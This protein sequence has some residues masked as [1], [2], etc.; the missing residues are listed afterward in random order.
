MQNYATPQLAAIPFYNEKSVCRII[1]NGYEKHLNIINIYFGLKFI[2]CEHTF[3]KKFTYLCDNIFANAYS[4][5][6]NAINNIKA[7]ALFLFPKIA[8]LRNQHE[9]KCNAHVFAWALLL[10][11]G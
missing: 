1:R 7:L 8:N 5:K 11:A 6:L 10:L 9:V 2:W 3:Y 4:V